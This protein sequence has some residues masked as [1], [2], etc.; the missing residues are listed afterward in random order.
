MPCSIQMAKPSPLP[1]I[2]E[3]DGHFDVVE[4]FLT[5]HKHDLH[6]VIQAAK[7]PCQEGAV[8][9]LPPCTYIQYS[10]IGFWPYKYQSIAKAAQNGPTENLEL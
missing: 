5:V 10:K 8:P 4:N 1:K 2:I 6:S 9:L 7:M 3:L